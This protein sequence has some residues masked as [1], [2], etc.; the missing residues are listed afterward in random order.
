MRTKSLAWQAR[1]KQLRAQLDAKQSTIVDVE[2]VHRNLMDIVRQLREKDGA[3]TARCAALSDDN[4]VLTIQAKQLKK[5]N[6]HKSSFLVQLGDT[7]KAEQARVSTLQAQLWVLNKDLA[8]AK[9]QI[10]T[11]KDGVR[12]ERQATKRVAAERDVASNRASVMAKFLTLLQSIYPTQFSSVCDELCSAQA[13]N[14]LDLPSDDKRI[15]Q[16]HL[17]VIMSDAMAVA[18]SAAAASATTESKA[19]A[20]ASPAEHKQA[21]AFATDA[22][23]VLM[24]DVQIAMAKKKAPASS[25]A[26]RRRR[27]PVKKASFLTRMSQPKKSTRKKKQSSS[28]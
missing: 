2:H 1:H 12:T 11:A 18:S 19:A 7:V 26:G 8:A 3:S 16:E 20:A 15:F 17:Q 9:Q 10:E 5:E 21:P 24:S 23:S 27:K 22:F 6:E 25:T 13:F 14:A 4:A 28:K